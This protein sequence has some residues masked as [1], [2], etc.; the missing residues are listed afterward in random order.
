MLYSDLMRYHEAIVLLQQYLHILD[1][2]LLTNSTNNTNSSSGFIN[3]KND[4]YIHKE[5]N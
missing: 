1:T 4:K 5:G 3:I 2:I